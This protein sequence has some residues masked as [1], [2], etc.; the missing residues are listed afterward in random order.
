MYLF[1]IWKML[2]YLGFLLAFHAFLC[3]G[4]I[5]STDKLS[6]FLPLLAIQFEDNFENDDNG[7]K[8]MNSVQF[9]TP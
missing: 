3:I 9:Q 2:V 8:E 4:E 1:F 6:T 7:S 5:T